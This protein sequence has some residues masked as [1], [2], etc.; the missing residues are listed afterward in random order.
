VQAIVPANTM[1]EP[2]DG[3]RPLL[4]YLN[5]AQKSVFMEAY[6]LSDRSILHSL[7]RAAAQRVSVF[8]LLEHRPFGLGTYPDHIASELQAAGVHVR[9]SSPRFTYTHAK[10]LV[11][12]DR[13]A[14][15]STANFSRS[16]FDGNREVIEVDR[17]RGDVHELSNIFRADWD[18]LPATLDS[19]D[20]VVAP[21]NAR[22]RFAGLIDSA[23]HSIEIYAEEFQDPRMEGL[24]ASRA[25]THVSVRILLPPSAS[26][27]LT[28]AET[29][30]LGIRTLGSPYIHAKVIIVDDR[31]AFVGSENFSQTSLDKN[32]EV[33]LFTR[34]PSLVRLEKVFQ[35]DWNR[36]RVARHS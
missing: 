7:E 26:S 3:V 18:N 8:V 33:G 13:T 9:W 22:A 35:T 2:D 11:L 4:A 28:K 21:S 15:V 36:A 19:P 6:I 25:R 29:A 20:L 24:L 17:T 30:T 34:G 12:D 32:R 16:A 10:F 1:V 23:R 5:R 27:H 31:V 14:V